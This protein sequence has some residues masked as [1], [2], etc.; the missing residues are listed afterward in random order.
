MKV[1]VLMIILLVFVSISCKQEPMSKNNTT[2]AEN[3][4]AAKLFI[5][6]KRDIAKYSTQYI[7]N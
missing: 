6:D 3:F 1:N 2:F 7:T 4:D 5:A